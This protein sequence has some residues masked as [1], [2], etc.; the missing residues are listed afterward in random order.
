M[1]LCQGFG[2]L[3]PS[4]SVLSNGGVI[5]YTENANNKPGTHNATERLHEV[6]SLH[7]E[8]T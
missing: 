4:R 7:L 8:S 2:A 6:V 3:L 1:A 5:A